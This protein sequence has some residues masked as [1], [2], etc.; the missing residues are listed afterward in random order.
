MCAPNR[1]LLLSTQSLREGDDA[2]SARVKLI[3]LAKTELFIINDQRLLHKAIA[4]Q[5]SK[6]TL[7]LLIKCGGDINLKDNIQGETPLHIAAA[8]LNNDLIPWLLQHG[9]N[10]GCALNSGE[11]PLDVLKIRFQQSVV[12]YRE[13]HIFIG[14]DRCKEHLDSILLLMSE[15]ESPVTSFAGGWLSPRMAFR[16]R[17]HA[18]IQADG[19]GNLCYLPNNVYRSNKHK[20]SFF[21]GYEECF[22]VVAL[23]LRRHRVPTVQ[24]LLAYVNSAH[25]SPSRGKIKKYLEMGGKFEYVLDAIIGIAATDDDD[26]VTENDKFLSL[27]MTALD[28]EFEIAKAMT[29]EFG[30]GHGTVDGRG[31]FAYRFRED[32]DS[33]YDE[34]EFW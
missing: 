34:E 16:L 15:E 27:P 1:V 4:F 12:M 25:P 6:E 28:D 29:V 17:C 19:D 10:K 14:A 33:S 22:G 3:Q 18:E 23:F 32:C 24:A 13:D 2:A 7:E 26:Y 5:L 20:Y 31:P 8:Q 9:A 21:D 30:G 11:T